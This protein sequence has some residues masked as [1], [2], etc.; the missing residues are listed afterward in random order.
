MIRQKIQEKLG[1]IVRELWPDL[2]VGML[3]VVL[4]KPLHADFGDYASNIAFK[5]AKEAG[6]SAGDIAEDIKKNLE[7]QDISELRAIDIRDGYINFFLSDDYVRS[8]LG[9]IAEY[10]GDYGHS[11]L[12]QGQTVIVEYPSTNIAKP[13]HVGHSRTAFIG[14]ALANIYEALGYEVVRWDYLG[15]WG[16]QFGKLIV[17]YKKWGDKKA[18]EKAPIAT[19]LD[20]YI[21]FSAEAK[22]KP[23]LEQE[24]RDEFKKLEDGDTENRELWEWFKKES[25]KESDAMYARL[26]L[27]EIDV[28]IGESFYEKEMQSLI[29]ELLE[30][31]IAKHN[32]GAVVVDLEKFGLPTALLQK[33]DGASVYLTRDIANLRYRLK[34]YKP[35]KILYVVANQQALHFEQL[36][37]LAQLLGLT[38]AELIHIKYGLVL[39][40]DR[41]KFSTRDG[42]MI[43]LQD[44]VEEAYKRAHLIVH[45]KN[46]A[47]ALAPAGKPELDE[48][49]KRKIAEVVSIGALKYN[50][51]KEYR[52]T[53]IV[54]DWDRI[55]DFNGNSG[56]YLQY[57]YARLQSILGKVNAIEQYDLTTLD[58]PAELFLIKHFL[59]FADVIEKSAVTYAPNHLA[60]YLY[61]L[62]NRANA[63]YEAVRI[64][65]DTNALRRNARLKLIEITGHILKNGLALLGISTLDR[66]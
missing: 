47:F 17:A 66:I 25:L 62:A 22:D 40:S 3:N 4:E 18:V 53:D 6:K 32:E 24:A 20:L 51:L 45:E 60:L 37:A 2:A 23:E 42:R 11:D 46:P 9:E 54:F 19:L 57:S 13:M 5:L 26:G 14:D 65:E 56:P 41:K 10:V 59:D 33:S 27:H 21:K 50:D 39:G 63:F 64:L 8:A 7:S 30:K 49:E 28:N 16:T 12:G 58:N 15:D 1:Q 31:G 44:V 34:K 29:D 36:F 52:T 48:D 35:S 43:E 55:L 61:D 38:D